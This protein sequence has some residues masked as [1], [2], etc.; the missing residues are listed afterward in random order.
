MDTSE[1]GPQQLVVDISEGVGGRGRHN[2]RLKHGRWSDRSWC[3][4][5]VSHG[6]E[7]LIVVLK[8]GNRHCSDVKIILPICKTRDQLILTVE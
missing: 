3:N 1:G 5:R 4:M 6:V 2:W 7:R 8:S